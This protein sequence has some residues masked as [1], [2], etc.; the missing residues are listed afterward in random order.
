[1][2]LRTVT[3]IEKLSTYILLPGTPASSARVERVRRLIKY[4]YQSRGYIES[5]G[6]WKLPIINEARNYFLVKGPK[7]S[8]PRYSS[9]NNV[10]AMKAHV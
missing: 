8:R 6:R 3:Q 10:L 9:S 5:L 1:M 7:K 2:L 4:R